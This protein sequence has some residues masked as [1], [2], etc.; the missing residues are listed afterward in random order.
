MSPS[1][2]LVSST[3]I[4]YSLLNSPRKHLVLILLAN[5]TVPFVESVIIACISSSPTL[6][7]KDSYRW[8]H[9]YWSRAVET[10]NR[11]VVTKPTLFNVWYSIFYSH[12]ILQKLG[13]GGSSSL[14]WRRIDNVFDDIV[15]CLVLPWFDS[16]RIFL[17]NFYEKH[18]GVW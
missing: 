1:P 18:V 4:W 2:S 12:V 16:I 17:N 14:L 8:V 11:T 10:E 13:S 5:V 7:R 9:N 3:H 15:I 6:Y